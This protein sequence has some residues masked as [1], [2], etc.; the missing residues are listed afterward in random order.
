M[1]PVL[2]L[3]VKENNKT[4]CRIRKFRAR[5]CEVWVWL[6]LVATPI[7]FSNLLWHSH[8]SVQRPLSFA[9]QTT[10]LYLLVRLIHIIKYS[11]LFTCTPLEFIMA[12]RLVPVQRP[13]SF[14]K[15]T[16]VLYCTLHDWFPRSMLVFMKGHYRS[17]T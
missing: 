6:K 12:H 15:Q 3:L 7:N 10:E 16:T 17:V 2:T 8:A 14:V 13:L 9:K 4:R 11:L 5:L 1:P